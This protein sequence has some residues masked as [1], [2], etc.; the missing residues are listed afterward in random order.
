LK[1]I[2][3]VAIALAFFA[4]AKKVEPPATKSLT[5]VTLNL[6]PSITY[7]PLMIAKD[8]G[9]FT[10][11]G[12]DAE[13]VSLDSNSA[14]AAAVAGK[15]DVLSAGVRSGVFN[16]IRRG[17]P[18]QIVADKG[19]ST[20]GDC[21]QEAFV[22][23]P[24]MAK[25]IAARGTL[26][27]ERLAVIRG[28]IAEYLIARLLDHY[29]LSNDDVVLV[30]L[31]QGS[32]VSSRSTLDAIRYVGEPHLSSLV[33]DGA[34]AVVATPEEVAP[35]HQSTI[36]VYGKRLLRDDPD[37]GRRF[38]RAYLRGVRRFNE[39]KTERN[40]AI[41]SRY[42]KLPPELIRASCWISIASDG[43]IDPKAVQPFL[44]WALEKRYLDGPVETSAWWN[45][46]FIEAAQ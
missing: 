40:L 29:S 5:R 7:A 33:A 16:M 10:D 15:L 25:R 41:I 46:S 1:R 2:A 27:G 22:A 20:K 4:C 36:I 31:P 17:E 13:L 23:P 44:D 18:L 32:P 34:A 3:V 37:L 30:N 42:T 19:H 45:P 14:L 9:F 12:I 11:E 24:A 43:R 28:G 26:R 21:V 35:G 38:M 39:G 8:E 6:N